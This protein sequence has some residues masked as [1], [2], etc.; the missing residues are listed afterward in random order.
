MLVIERRAA[1]KAEW[2]PARHEV[3]PL[4]GFIYFSGRGSLPREPFLVAQL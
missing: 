4:G 3:R 2:N 1:G